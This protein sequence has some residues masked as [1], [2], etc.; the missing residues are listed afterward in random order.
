MATFKICI[1]EH[2]KRDDGKYPV[3]IRVYWKKQSAYIGTE[4]YV[5]IKQINNKAYKLIDGKVKKKFELKDTFIINQLNT[6]I[7]E[8]EK[9][10]VQKLGYNIELYSARDL[11]EYLKKE[12]SPGTD[13]SIDF[14]DFSRKHCDR[15]VAAGKKKT[16]GTLM[17]PLNAIIDFCNGRKKVPITEIN[18]KFLNEFELYLR[19]ERKLKRKNQFG[20]VV[21]TIRPGLSDTGIHD[22]MTA[23]RILFNA[24]RDEF[25]DEDRDEL[26]IKHYPFR[27][28]K[29]GKTRQPIKRVLTIDQ[30]RSILALKD[31]KLTQKRAI[32][33]H[34]VFLLSLYLA[35]TNLTDLYHAKM[36]C[37]IDGRFS[38]ERQ[39]TKDRR[40][41]RAY[42]SIKVQ[43][44]AIPFF[45]KYKDPQG[46]FVFCFA[47]LYSDHDTFETAINKGLKF[48]ATAC[49]IDK[50]TS[51]HAR[52]S[53]ATI[54]R[55]D[56]GVSRD[57]IDLALNHVDQ[58]LKITDGYIKRDWSIVDKTVR[59]VIDNLGTK[60]NN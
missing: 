9:I 7:E 11:A 37:Y 59:K 44:E 17:T 24:A 6:R 34:D 16:A 23:I 36:E 15:L 13:G 50:I 2:Q 10:K 54:A 57:D 30:I 27:K 18:V 4:Y 26:R 53:F 33:A 25:N 1:F 31:E 21:E 49:K 20:N 47:R 42:I 12:A 58:A 55:N 39:K 38:Y 8:Y 35:G 28:Y 43:P 40:Q 29:I 46:E 51:Y 52:F 14:I 56:C 3:S 41:D 48:I 45:E 19:Q 32:L 60:A 22:Y 5:T